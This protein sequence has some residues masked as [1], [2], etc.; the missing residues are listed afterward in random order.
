M[1]LGDVAHPAAF[2][3]EDL[4]EQLRACPGR[5]I[6]VLGNHDLVLR[7]ELEEAGFRDQCAA[8]LCGIDPA[9]ALTHMPLHPV[10][11]GCVHLYGH[12]HSRGDQAPRHLD[13]GVD[14]IGFAPRRLDWLLEDLA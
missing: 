14:A 13:V 1:C 6:L 8:A 12:L 7:R 10:P 4:V 5:R 11:Y 3:D 9:A 2:D